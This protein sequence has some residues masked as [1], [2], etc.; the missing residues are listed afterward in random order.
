MARLRA[1]FTYANV[2]STLCLFVVLGGGAMAAGIVPFAKKA[3]D[4][5]RV[6]GISASR[7]PKPNRLLAL[8]AKGK[9]P[10]SVLPAAAAGAKGETGATGPAGPAGPKGDTGATGP[11]GPTSSPPTTFN[12]LG[13]ITNYYKNGSKYLPITPETSA[14]LA[15]DR[16]VI[17]NAITNTSDWE[18]YV[19]YETIPPGGTCQPFSSGHRLIT[20]LNIK[21][22][23]TETDTFATPVVYK[24]TPGAPMWCIVGG[25]GPTQNT[26]STTDSGF[27]D[28]QVSGYVVSGSYSGT[29]DSAAARQPRE[30]RLAG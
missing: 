20:H 25:G 16:I 28:I 23:G 10:A 13:S 15:V 27:T 6:S 24:P 22:H 26:A 1:A 29:T 7:K 5:S 11:A 2:V 21:S 9:F 8:D 17:T 3:G 12:T 14:T 19:Y 30:D 18:V 4:A